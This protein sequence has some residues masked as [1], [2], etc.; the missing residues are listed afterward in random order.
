[1]TTIINLFAGPGAGKSTTAAG[2]FH[3][4]KLNNFHVE[5]V[6]EAAKDMIWEQRNKTLENQFYVSAKQHQR[7]FRI[8]QYFE[9][10]NIKN[11]YII[12]DSPLILGIIY[13]KSSNP[14]LDKFL[15]HEFYHYG[16]FEIL[17]MN[18]F[19]NRDE[20]YTEIGRNQKFNEAVEID[21]KVYDLLEYYAIPFY[22]VDKKTAVDEI[23][24]KIQDTRSK[25]IILKN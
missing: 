3:K 7:I 10:H 11:G 2:L 22:E 6:T 4:M 12:T 16:N 14:F 20:N 19:I 24:Q 21:E 25:K 15:I 1:M 23:F 18:F 17:N 9:D 5:L 8:L 13:S